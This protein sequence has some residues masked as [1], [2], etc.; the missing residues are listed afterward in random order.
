MEGPAEI[1]RR[2]KIL[3]QEGNRCSKTGDFTHASSHYLSAIKLL[4]FAYVVL[5]EDDIT[6]K[7]LA[8]T[9]NINMVASELKLERFE[10]VMQLCS[11]GLT[12]AIQRLYS[13]DQK[14]LWVCITF[15]K[16]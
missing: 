6:F 9:L 1:F 13:E 10:K 14:Q 5:K 2:V 11:L 4:C 12:L 7:Q 16:H 15:N 3:K 8:I